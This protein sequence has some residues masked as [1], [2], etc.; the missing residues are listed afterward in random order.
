VLP[1]DG[2]YTVRV[3]LIRAAARR[4]E[5]GSYALDIGVGGKALAALPA[6]V[7]ALIPGTPYHASASIPCADTFDPKVRECEAFVIRRG[8]DGT[9]TVEIRWPIG[10]KRRV[11]FLQGKPVA[12]DAPD[13]LAV[14]RRG[15]TSIVSI[16]GGE[17]L[18]IPDALLFG[19]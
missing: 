16:G 10:T 6:S 8:H 19:G 4:N 2:D 7:D 18:E 5:S 12:S 9:A 11:L 14:S 17:R 15:D 13:A 1:A 3:Y